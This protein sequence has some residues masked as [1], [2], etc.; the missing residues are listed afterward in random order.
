MQQEV[1]DR[2]GV[3]VESVKNWERDAGAPTIQQIPKIIEFLGYDPNPAPRTAPDQVAQARRCLGLTQEAL[4]EKIGVDPV[5]VYRWEKG[6]SVP[7]AKT[8]QRLR[9]LLP[10]KPSTTPR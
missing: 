3:H 1:A 7:P 10:G 5:T 9:G 6:L 2:L 4:A 8:L